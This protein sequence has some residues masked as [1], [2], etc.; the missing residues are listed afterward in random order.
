MDD[1]YYREKFKELGLSEQ[2]EFVGRD[3]SSYKGRKVIVRC[4]T[5]GTEFYTWGFNEMLKGRQ[6]HLLCIECGAASD[7]ADVWER[8]PRCDEAMAHYADGH[9]VRQTAEKFGVPESQINNSVKKRGLTNG[10]Q[11]GEISDEQRERQRYEAEQRLIE[12]LDVLGFDYIGGYTTSDESVMI[13]CRSCGDVFERTVG[14]IK[15]GNLICKKCEHEKTLIRQAEQR[16]VRKAEAERKKAERKM[17]R[18]AKPSAYQLSQMALLDDTHTCKVCGKEYTL[19]EYMESTGSRYYR[20]S[21]YCSA[22]CRDAYNKE[23]AKISHKGRR[24]SH[25][26]RAVKYGCA[27]DSSV[28]LAKLIKRN[29]LRCAICGEMCDPKDHSWS[30]YSGPMYPSI[31][32]IV[33]MSKG[34]GHVWNNVQVAHI[35]CNSE[36]GACDYE[37]KTGEKI[38]TESRDSHKGDPVYAGEAH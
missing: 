38:Q 26:Y 7:G 9:T 17:A 4:K 3:Y 19:R 34:G 24:D 16:M 11:W 37:S 2:F 14:F 27:Y 8:S 23:C 30:Q 20:D 15:T 36:K 28:T 35:I 25:R 5:C 6:S 10:R 29:G 22:D 21:G 32:H 12:R 33:P 13:K 1:K 31:D 18:A